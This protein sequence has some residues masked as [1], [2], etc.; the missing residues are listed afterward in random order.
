MQLLKRDDDK[1]LLHHEGH[2]FQTSLLEH[3]YLTGMDGKPDERFLLTPQL[4][5][6]DRGCSYT[7]RTSFPVHGDGESQ[8]Y[9]VHY[10]HAIGR[11]RTLRLA[12]R[13]VRDSC[14]QAGG[15]PMIS[16]GDFPEENDDAASDARQDS[17][18]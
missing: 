11:H 9:H 3:S 18:P 5:C 16:E 14:R 2:T 15:V 1:V 17:A 8:R 7:C 4:L 12:A 13:A 6:V 10:R